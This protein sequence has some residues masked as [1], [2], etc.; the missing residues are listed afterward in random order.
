MPSCISPNSDEYLSIQQ[1]CVLTRSNFSLY[2]WS[3][4]ILL[5]PGW[6]PSP[7]SW[8]CWSQTCLQ[9][10]LLLLAP[11]QQTNHDMTFV[12][13]HNSPLK[14]K[15]AKCKFN[16]CLR[17]AQF[18]DQFGVNEQMKFNSPQSTQ[19]FI[20]YLQSGACSTCRSIVHDGWV[21]SN[22]FE[23][24]CTLS[25][26]DELESN[27]PRERHDRSGWPWWTAEGLD[28]PGQA[29]WPCRAHICLA[30]WFIAQIGL[31]FAFLY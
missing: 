31:L 1:Y 18:T 7:P 28:Q 21:V 19:I 6:S 14:P 12:I 5:S 26:A 13:D 16:Q 10:H 17:L 25:V 24:K 3:A 30:L 8:Q 27:E 9:C 4:S 23:A 22:L 2:L 15:S 11:D 20:N 29:P